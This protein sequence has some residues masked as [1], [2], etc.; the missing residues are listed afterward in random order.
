MIIPR[1]KS[2]I[3]T[4]NVWKYTGA[5]ALT[6]EKCSFSR[7]VERALKLFLPDSELCSCGC[8]LIFR[9]TEEK[10]QD[11]WYRIT[12]TENEI[13]AEFC[14]KRGAINAAAS[15]ACLALDGEA[16]CG[17]IED[18]PDYP[19]RGVMLDLSRG[20]REQLQDVK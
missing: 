14:D 7:D 20:I 10:K 3:K 6:F 15:L 12:L 4:K 11:E 13:T 1:V 8:K 19:H 18:Y 5:F 9:R 2:Y 17:V 16:L